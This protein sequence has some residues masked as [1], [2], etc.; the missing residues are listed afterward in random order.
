MT[1]FWL[2]LGWMLLIPMAGIYGATLICTLIVGVRMAVNAVRTRRLLRDYLER[3][4]CMALIPIPMVGLWW[5]TM[6]CVV[7]MGL[8]LV[9]RPRYVDARSP[10]DQSIDRSL[11]VDRYYFNH[12]TEDL[13]TRNSFNP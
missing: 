12:S 2:F 10:I 7:W 9:F 1:L 6:I 13:R 8:R 11:E 3:E 4:V 5:A